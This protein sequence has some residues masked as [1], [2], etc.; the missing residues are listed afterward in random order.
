MVLTEIMHGPPNVPVQHLHTVAG[1]GNAS[2]NF[3]TMLYGEELW[4]LTVVVQK[5]NPEAA[6]HNFQR[7]IM[8]IHKKIKLVTRE[9]GHR[10][11]WRR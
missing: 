8:G 11:D 9:S 1:D 3:I 7:R 2:I 5:K 10:N 4:P 6:R